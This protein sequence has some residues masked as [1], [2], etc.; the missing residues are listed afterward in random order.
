LRRIHA[1]IADID[2]LCDAPRVKLWFFCICLLFVSA[3]TRQLEV[4]TA[5][6]SNDF[7]GLSDDERKAGPKWAAFEVSVPRSVARSIRRWQLSNVTLKIFRC[8]N[9]VDAYSAEARLDG[10]PF[11]Y[12]NLK[13]PLA[14]SVRLTFYVPLKPEAREASACA[15]FDARGVLPVF[16]RGQT[17]HLPPL[18][19][20][21]PHF[22]E[23]TGRISST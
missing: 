19:M 20:T 21:F 8:D 15:A 10:R 23:K 17:D 14:P 9:P 13:E 6:L 18:K 2:R 1:S 16:L 22:D 11:E 4:S 7:S 12:E 3:C 5:K